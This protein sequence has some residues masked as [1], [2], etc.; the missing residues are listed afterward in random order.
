MIIEVK[1]LPLK[2]WHGKKDS[3]SFT[4]PKGVEVLYDPETGY[5]ATGLTNEETVEY[6]KKTGLDLS[7]T[8]VPDMP[9]PY[10]STRSA[11][12]K[13]ENATMF[14]NTER[15]LEY[16]KYKNLKASKFVANSLEEQEKGMWPDATHY[17]SSVELD[18]VVEASKIEKKNKAIGI[19]NALSPQEKVAIIQILSDKTVTAQS[20]NFIAIEID[21]LIQEKTDDFLR[22]AQ[23]EKTELNLRATVLEAL[24]KGILT[25]QGTAIYYMGDRIGFDVDEVVKSFNSTDNQALKVAVL[26]KLTK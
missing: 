1:P 14:L 3:E 19:S 13:L 8:F 5:Y 9:H 10:W 11:L 25:K 4:R 22:W 26:E 23:M 20:A 2:K 7:K 12:I 6:E 21:K 18:L 24:A 16:I 17:I 15:P